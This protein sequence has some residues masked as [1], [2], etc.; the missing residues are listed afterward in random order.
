MSAAKG[1]VSQNAKYHATLKAAFVENF[2][3][4]RLLKSPD[5]LI[6]TQSDC[7]MLELECAVQSY[8]WGKRGNTSKV[9]QLK[10]RITR[11]TCDWQHSVLSVSSRFMNRA[12]NWMRNFHMQN[13]G[14]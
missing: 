3:S 8:K 7:Q 4:F 1:T 14:L 2:D 6:N 9:A 13:Y 5:W 11:S 10:V 12:L